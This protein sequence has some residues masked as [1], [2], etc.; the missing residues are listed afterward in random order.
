LHLSNWKLSC[1]C[2]KC[3]EK[4]L[5]AD[6]D[7]AMVLHAD[8][9]RTFLGRGKWA[10]KKLP[11]HVYCKKCGEIKGEETNCDLSVVATPAGIN[12]LLWIL[13][14]VGVIAVLIY[15]FIKNI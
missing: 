10:F 12:K 8:Y 3:K 4:P 11:S 6:I 13:V 1:I 9:F 7:A 15:S 14:I 5:Y 2:P